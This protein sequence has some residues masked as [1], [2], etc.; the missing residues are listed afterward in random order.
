MLFF[1]HTAT[2]QPHV[3]T[4]IAELLNHWIH[5]LQDSET[6][7]ATHLTP[8]LIAGAFDLGATYLF[9]ITAKT[10]RSNTN[11]VLTSNTFQMWHTLIQHRDIFLPNIATEWEKTL[12]KATQHLITLI[13]ILIE[14]YAGDTVTS[15]LKIR[16]F[17][18]Q[19]PLLPA[20]KIPFPF[21]TKFFIAI[22]EQDSAGTL[23]DH[24][25]HMA[26]TLSKALILRMSEQPLPIALFEPL[27]IFL[28]DRLGH[29]GNEDAS[30]FKFLA[31]AHWPDPTLKLSTNTADALYNMGYQVDN[32]HCGRDFSELFCLGIVPRLSEE[33][34]IVFRN[35]SLLE[36]NSKDAIFDFMDELFSVGVLQILD[37]KDLL[38]GKTLARILANTQRLP[39]YPETNFDVLI[40]NQIVHCP[41]TVLHPALPYIRESGQLIRFCLD[42]TLPPG[43]AISTDVKTPLL[44][45]LTKAFLEQNNPLP[46]ILSAIFCNT[47]LTANQTK[48]RQELITQHINT[49]APTLPTQQF[50][51]E[52]RKIKDTEQGKHLLTEIVLGKALPGRE[53]FLTA[54]S[55]TP[56]AKEIGFK[57]LLEGQTLPAPWYT[58][59]LDHGRLT[60]LEKTLRFL[61]TPEIKTQH[62]G[63]SD[64]ISAILPKLCETW[65]NTPKPNPDLI[66]PLLHHPCPH[67]KWV[68][69]AHILADVT[70]PKGLAEAVVSSCYVR[71]SDNDT[72]LIAQ[73]TLASQ[74]V[75]DA[76]QRF[77][78][79]IWSRLSLI[80]ASNSHWS[81]QTLGTMLSGITSCPQRWPYL[82]VTL[83]RCCQSATEGP[84][85]RVLSSTMATFSPEHHQAEWHSILRDLPKPKHPMAVRL[86]MESPTPLRYLRLM[87]SI[88]YAEVAIRSVLS[89]GNSDIQRKFIPNYIQ[90][91][92]KTD[93]ASLS[94][95][96]KHTCEVGN[97]SSNTVVSEIYLAHW[98]QQQPN[99]PLS[100]M[101]SD[102]L[103]TCIKET[104][105]SLF[106][107]DNPYLAMIPKA[108]W[109]ALN[110]VLQNHQNPLF[111]KACTL[112]QLCPDKVSHAIQQKYPW[113]CNPQG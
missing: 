94:E 22:V 28:Q 60:D 101:I 108:L 11:L 110:E 44:L 29:L 83:S 96:F 106:Q 7:N 98:Q 95:L 35:S 34:R 36:R 103:N 18:E 10:I 15:L 111:S 31:Y 8:A 72:V 47:T 2:T 56:L 63:L 6:P 59:S 86:A 75:P 41:K 90:H 21:I 73:T 77:S 89:E 53:A 16:L 58:P 69:F 4:T 100:H 24:R 40:A 91:L 99:T 109:E 64:N 52:F 71:T 81:T 79:A 84:L 67:N 92:T 61:A 87:L 107:R 3:Y 37:P 76:G 57:L 42:G 105:Y 1:K 74:T 51:K 13:P 102:V 113:L 82:H 46:P 17:T 14:D 50:E 5:Q 32:P 55:D 25:D 93:H 27:A 88:G 45:A 65:I 80:T 9:G 38:I 62:P 68:A 70:L 43:T 78:D 33:A 39:H 48:E 54:I 30:F 26:Q 49:L 20:E 112:A 97:A 104:P 85:Q 23:N 66:H 12:T 19:L